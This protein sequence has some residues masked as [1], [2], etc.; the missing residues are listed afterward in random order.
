[1]ARKEKALTEEQ[2]AALR[3]NSLNPLLREILQDL[4]KSIIVRNRITGEFRVINK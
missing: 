1:M 2:V 3:K 4:T